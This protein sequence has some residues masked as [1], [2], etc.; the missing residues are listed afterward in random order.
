M[1]YVCSKEPDP[2]EANLQETKPLRFLTRTF[3]CC[4]YLYSELNTAAR[5]P[6]RIIEMKM[7]ETQSLELKGQQLG[8]RKSGWRVT[9]KGLLE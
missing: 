8:G 9:W 3:K 7:T 5:E 4:P 2:P 1:K 6:H